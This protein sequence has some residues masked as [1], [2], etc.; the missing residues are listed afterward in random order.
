MPSYILPD[1]LMARQPT[2]LEIAEENTGR[3]LRIDNAIRETDAK[4]RVQRAWDTL[5]GVESDAPQSGY[6][7]LFGAPQRAQSE[8]RSREDAAAFL[9]ARDPDRFTKT[10]EAVGGF[11]ANS[12]IPVLRA[13]P[14]PRARVEQL[15]RLAQTGPPML[16]ALV[17]DISSD[18][19]ITDDEIAQAE[20]MFAGYASVPEG[21]EWRAGGG[22]S[23][24]VFR[25]GRGGELETA[26][27]PG[28]KATSDYTGEAAN[29][30]AAYAA[31]ERNPNDP[32]ARAVI[33]KH[34]AS[35]RPTGGSGSGRAPTEL[36]QARA[37]IRNPS[38]YLPQEVA[39]AERKLT[40]G[41]GGPTVEMTDS[42]G[43][44]VI[45][46]FDGG[47]TGDKVR[48]RKYQDKLDQLYTVR[49]LLRSYGAD[50]NSRYGNL[51]PSAAGISGRVIS[52]VN[53]L[54]NQVEGVPGVEQARGILAS[55]GITATPQQRQQ[56]A[57][58]RQKAYQLTR[59]L[60]A[61]F[62]QD[63]RMSDADARYAEGLLRFL[64]ATGSV[65][66]ARVA[67]G[68]LNELVEQQISYYSARL[69]GAP[70]SSA[71]QP[72]VRIDVP[73]STGRGQGDR[74]LRFE[75]LD[76]LRQRLGVPP[77]GRR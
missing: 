24:V 5:E 72:G 77:P 58:I 35:L 12:A 38:A 4:N 59:P 53:G 8:F 67:F 21:S 25:T 19:V 61:L 76:Q 18:G 51:P 17:A 63:N 56:V 26:V 68:L 31:L 41:G 47:T 13:T 73:A 29:L 49:N 1:E 66:E 28:G 22:G 65:P 32:V 20:Q 44:P 14:D 27:L 52:A 46:S 30:Q 60:M 40:G 6:S 48:D 57:S 11:M 37:I 15:S 75:S 70:A 10:M 39:W 74:P 64:D 50:L 45:F 2:L 42:A 36:D 62:Q 33:A 71:A 16:R 69:D 43:N 9:R 55:A 34:E 3:R 23:G 54:L 7:M